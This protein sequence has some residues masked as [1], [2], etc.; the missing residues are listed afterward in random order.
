MILEDSVELVD[1]SDSCIIQVQAF[2]STLQV[3]ICFMSRVSAFFIDM[4]QG[5]DNRILWNG[6]VVEVAHTMHHMKFHFHCD[7]RSDGANEGCGGAI[8]RV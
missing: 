4:I 3:P 8:D 7:R 6:E 5:S 2:S 1:C